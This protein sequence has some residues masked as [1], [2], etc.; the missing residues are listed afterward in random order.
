[1]FVTLAGAN[2]AF[3]TIGAERD[4]IVN[5][6]NVRGGAGGDHLTGDAGANQLFGGEGSDSLA[7]AGGKDALDGGA[8]D[9]I[10]D[11]GDGNDSLG[12]GVG[13][14]T[15]TGGGGDDFLDSGSGGDTL[16]GGT[17]IDV[18]RGGFGSDVFVFDTAAGAGNVDR[19]EG[20]VHGVDGIVLAGIVFTG[21]SAGSLKGKYSHA[22]K[23]AHDGNDHI[24]FNEKKGALFY[25]EDGKG[26]LHQVKI[27]IL[28]GHPDI[29]RGDFLVA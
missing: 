27:A 7:G 11:G 17:G 1:M 10:L 3:A 8:G 12:A 24:I 19:I 9:D 6:E 21:L 23:K 22:G 13:D 2:P 18:L 28:T 26:G 16:A 20:F 14:D 5:F 4:S 25:D 29:D 15:L